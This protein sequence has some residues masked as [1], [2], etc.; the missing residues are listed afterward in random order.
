MT[1]KQKKDALRK[2]RAFCKDLNDNNYYQFY[3]NRK[4]G[5]IICTETAGGY[6][7]NNDRDIVELAWGTFKNDT[8][9]EYQFYQYYIRPEALRTM[10]NLTINHKIEG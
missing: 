2:I 3:V 6:V 9:T 5:K 7:E 10:Q 1:V 4:T 8:C